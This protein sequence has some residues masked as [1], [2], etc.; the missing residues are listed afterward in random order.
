[1]EIWTDVAGLFTADPRIVPEA[2]KLD[3]ISFEE[4]LE[5]SASGAGV[6]MSRIT[7][8]VNLIRNMVSDTVKASIRDV[9]SIVAL[10]GVIFYRDW[11]LALIAMVVL[12][13]TVFP[14]AK[15]GRRVRKVSTRNQETMAE[16]NACKGSSCDCCGGH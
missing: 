4:M 10:T 6:L 5:L 3:E 1:M 9:F 16:L 8:D 2:R 7:N 11:Q 15:F 12:P 13:I 14:I